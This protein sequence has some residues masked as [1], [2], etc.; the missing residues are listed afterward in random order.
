MLYRKRVYAASLAACADPELSED[1]AQETFLIAFRSLG[2][3]KAPE[4][5]ASWLCG[6][7]WKVARGF[8][9]RRTLDKRHSHEAPEPSGPQHQLMEKDRAETIY[10]GLSRLPERYRKALAM[11]YV[12]GLSYAQMAAE[13]GETV[14]GIESLLFRARKAFKESVP[15][16]GSLKES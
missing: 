9:R 12:E 7:A 6:I 8:I 3:L 10:R 13:L 16:L 5:F 1:V 14:S 11:R 15:E 2:Q 4:R